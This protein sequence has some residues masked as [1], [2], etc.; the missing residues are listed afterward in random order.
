MA[1]DY[2][3]PY[4]PYEP[5]EPYQAPLLIEVAPEEP[6]GRSWLRNCLFVSVSLIVVTSLL[7]ASLL[8]AFFT[9]ANNAE[10][11][12]ARELA[13]RRAEATALQTG[14]R[15]LPAPETSVLVEPLPTVG[16]LIADEVDE[17]DRIV[18]VT[19]DGQVETVNPDGRERRRLTSFNDGVFFQF[20]TWSPD[21]NQVA[22]IG[23]NRAGGGVFVL[24]DEQQRSELEESQ[25]YYSQTQVPIY[26]YWS[27]DSAQVAF[28][29]NHSRDTLG[30]N[31]VP[32]D[33]DIESR[34][35]ATGSPFYWE[36]AADSQVMLIHSGQTGE[37]ARLAAIGV[38]GAEQTPNLAEP[39]I[40]QAPGISPGGRYWAYA[41]EQGRGVSALVVA[42][43]ETGERQL[44]EQGGSIAMNWSPSSEQLAY[45]TGGIDAHPFWGPL[46]LTDME[47]GETRL[48]TS[49]TV[50]A[51]FW[52]PDGTKIAFIT[53]NQ[54]NEDVYAA[55][56]DRTQ[57][58]AR[59][60]APQPVQQRGGGFLELS[61]LDVKSGEGLQLLDFQP[62]AVFATQFMSF[63]A[64]YALSHRIWSPDST[65]L[66]VPMRDDNDS[67]IVVVPADGGTTAVIGEGDMAFWSQR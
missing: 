32:R 52:S 42:N 59:M 43:T 29:A 31:I 10:N 48:L 63:F 5:Y 8:T 64:Q 9:R 56:A 61:V 46:R 4:E 40:F 41:E 38:D 34:L 23:V 19:S 7:G 30:L 36:W 21:G 3:F 27:P 37:S 6:Q 35:L 47:S 49:K 33:G 24:D 50:L 25:V 39:G 15:P 60:A 17:L 28:L 18:I 44:I 20:P 53:L 54:R 62:T 11:E 2:D 1:D 16:A 26:L 57:L 22:A 55:S 66:L 67:R 13:Q 58:V 14:D 65:R 45:T 12:A 51:F